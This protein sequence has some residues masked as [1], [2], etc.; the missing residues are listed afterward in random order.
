MR[1]ADDLAV[2]GSGINLDDL[3]AL[4][5]L[6]SESSQNKR[7]AELG[8]TDTGD[9]HDSSIQSYDTMS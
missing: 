2:E 7:S 6:G 5:A 9:S 4:I 3:Q 8:Q 1:I